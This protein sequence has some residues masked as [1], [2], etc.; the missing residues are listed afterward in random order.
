MINSIT[1]RRVFTILTA[2]AA[3]FI[4]LPLPVMQYVGEDGLMAIK[5]YEMFIRDDWLHPSILGMIWPH[6]P[7]WHCP[8]IAISHLIG[9]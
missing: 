2:V 6:S 5:T 1:P 4:L 9:W 3:L 8:V 7:L